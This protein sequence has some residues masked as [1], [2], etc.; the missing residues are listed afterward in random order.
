VP[1]RPENV[2]WLRERAAPSVGDSRNASRSQGEP[3]P[4][5]RTCPLPAPRACPD[6][7]LTYADVEPVFAARC[8][9]CH[10]GEPNGPWPLDTYGHVATWRDTVRASLI[11]CTMPPPESGQTIADEES[12]LVLTWIRCGMPL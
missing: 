8:V 7:A 5:S 4:A 3:N 1:V 2:A 6:P 10:A 11:Q 9:V 12:A